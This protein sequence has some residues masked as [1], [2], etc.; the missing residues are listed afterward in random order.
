VR[1]GR[2]VQWRDYADSATVARGFASAGVK[3]TLDSSN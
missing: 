3:V 2:I 1:N